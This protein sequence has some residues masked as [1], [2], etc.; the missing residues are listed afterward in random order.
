MND[1]QKKEL[2]HELADK[3]IIELGKKIELQIESLVKPRLD[4]IEKQID[5]VQKSV[6]RI[7]ADMAGD[8]KDIG[9]LK[10]EMGTIRA[11]FNEIRELFGQQT[12]TLVNKLGDQLEKKVESVAE[13]VT[14]TTAAAVD[15]T[16]ESFTSG[17]PK[18]QKKTKSL[19]SRLKFWKWRFKK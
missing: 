18:I 9:N 19:L 10:T 2:S 4:N 6:N 5:T 16:L 8:R 3:L 12:R 7:D 14:E 17:A 13:V 15:A 11:Q 1:K